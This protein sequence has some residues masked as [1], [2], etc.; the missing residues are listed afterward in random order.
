MGNIKACRA[1]GGANGKNPHTIVVPCHRVIGQSGALTGFGAGIER[2]KWLLN[3][4]KKH[5]EK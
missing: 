2:K 1:V 5:S 3:H 4:E